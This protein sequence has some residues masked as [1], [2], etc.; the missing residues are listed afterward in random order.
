MNAQ[1]SVS[2]WLDQLKAGDSAALQPI[3]ERYFARLVSLTRRTSARGAVRF[4]R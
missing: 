2:L 4:G 1:G 3:W